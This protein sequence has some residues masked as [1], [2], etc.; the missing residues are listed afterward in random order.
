MPKTAFKTA[1]SET[2]Y[3]EIEQDLK[4]YTERYNNENYIDEY[5]DGCGIET[6]NEYDNLKNQMLS[7][8]YKN[9]GFWI[10]QYEAGIEEERT[11][12]SS[13]LPTPISKEGAY[14]Y[15]YIKLQDA[16][17][18]AN[19]L[20][21]NYLLDNQSTKTEDVTTS[22][23]MFGIQ[24]NLVMKFIE[25]NGPK[26]YSDISKNSASW[27]NYSNASF[28]ISK[29][30]NFKNSWYDTNNEY[31][32]EEN[33]NILLTTG[34]TDRNSVLN[35]YDLAGN[36]SEITLEKSENNKGVCRGGSYIDEGTQSVDEHQEINGEEANN[37]GFRIA[38][39]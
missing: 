13:S 4:S 23:L 5:F 36:L 33:D 2:D 24:W 38:I 32:K 1:K 31:T 34:A 14:P 37:I 8:I 20:M 18:V 19:K 21:Q 7:S 27:G 26:D 17:E 3:D 6:E 22:S 11:N 28:D 15:N 12:V 25:T 9:N 16:Q 29:G 39:Y 35:I 30:K 10:S